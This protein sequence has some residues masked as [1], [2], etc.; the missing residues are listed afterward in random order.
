MFILQ[1]KFGDKSSSREILFIRRSSLVIGS[2]SS[3]HVIMEGFPSNQ[4]LKLV[5]GLG[6]EF[7][8]GLV[9]S[10]NT[11][12]SSQSSCH[13]FASNESFPL[14]DGFTDFAFEACYV[15]IWCIDLDLIPLGEAPDVAAIKT[16]RQALST[17]KPIFPAI[18]ILD[19]FPVFYSFGGMDR[20][21]IGRSR[22]CF[23]RSDSSNLAAEHLSVWCEG[24]DFLVSL[25]P[26]LEDWKE[27]TY[28]GD[29]VLCNEYMRFSALTRV[30]IGD[31]FEFTAIRTIEDLRSLR[32][33][34]S[35]T[36]CDDVLGLTSEYPLVRLKQASDQDV[37]PS[38]AFS[39]NPTIIVG[40]DPLCHIRIEDSHISSE[41]VMLSLEDDRDVV[42]VDK[43]SNGTFYDGRRLKRYERLALGK[44]NAVIDLQLGTELIIEFLPSSQ[45][46]NNLN[47]VSYV[48][49]YDKRVGCKTDKQIQPIPTFNFEKF[50][51]DRADGNIEPPINLTEDSRSFFEHSHEARES[52]YSGN[53]YLAYDSSE[54]EACFSRDGL[55]RSGKLSRRVSSFE[56]KSSSVSLSQ[57]SSKLFSDDIAGVLANDISSP[58]YKFTKLKRLILGIFVLVLLFMA[59]LLTVILFTAN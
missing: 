42:I 37:K 54:T 16:L 43:S 50:L 18:V 28:V 1:V 48:T 56:P 8:C 21:L 59:V 9:N 30:R 7:Q 6:R 19:S 3:A 46:S 12:A 44:K 36:T 33:D 51:L 24:E 29:D 5:R 55:T 20:I 34:I 57:S 39:R 49:S 53:E 13:G 35:Y 45:Y 15:Q 11:L 32:E 40:R 38:L 23:V 4:V 26:D 27:K 52:N 31:S 17:K 41:H 14:Y 25:L 58:E 10:S 22:Q 47:L 2:G